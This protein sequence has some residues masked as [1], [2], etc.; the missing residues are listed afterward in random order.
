MFYLITQFK[1]ILSIENMWTNYVVKT[2]T[3]IN[4]N[5][6]SHKINL[7]LICNQK[8]KMIIIHTLYFKITEYK[9]L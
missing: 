6:Q 2:L 5:V 3:E 1:Y 7:I 4:A 8:L 9:D